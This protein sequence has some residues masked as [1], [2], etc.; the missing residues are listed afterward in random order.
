MAVKGIAKEI[1]AYACCYYG[2]S[3]IEALGGD[4]AKRPIAYN[5]IGTLSPT[6]IVLLSVDETQR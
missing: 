6:I 3:I 4:T 1:F 2:A 5:L